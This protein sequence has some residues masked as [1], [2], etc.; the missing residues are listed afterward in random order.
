MDDDDLIQDIGGDMERS[1]VSYLP[2][3]LVDDD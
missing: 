1:T 2:Q 3:R